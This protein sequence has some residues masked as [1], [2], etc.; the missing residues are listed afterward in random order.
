ME[1]PSRWSVHIIIIIIIIIILLLLLSLS[2]SILDCFGVE[3]PSRWSA[4]QQGRGARPAVFQT[5]DRMR[6]RLDTHTHTHTHVR[7]NL[8]IQ[9]QKRWNASQDRMRRRLVPTKAA[10]VGK[11]R[12]RSKAS[13]PLGLPS[14]GPLTA[15]APAPFTARSPRRHGPAGLQQETRHSNMRLPSPRRKSLRDPSPVADGRPRLSCGCRR[16]PI[17]RIE[18]AQVEGEQG[19]R[20]VK[21]SA[22]CAVQ[23]P[24]FLRQK[25]SSALESIG[26]RKSSVALM[27]SAAGFFHLQQ[28]SAGC[29]ASIVAQV[30]SLAVQCR[31]PRPHAT[32][33]LNSPS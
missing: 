25:S 29:T 31:I 7:K 1:A 5:Q 11:S 24:R 12:R 14:A 20:P 2:S 6:R 30:A 15:A 23:C 17:P 19:A 9:Y 21:F 33:S 4:A 18:R 10:F 3:A 28:R 8:I 26:A 16:W 13:R 22:A 32:P 27:L